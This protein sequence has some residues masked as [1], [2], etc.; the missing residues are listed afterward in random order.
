MDR[1]ERTNRIIAWSLGGLALVVYLMTTAP[2][3][4]FWDNGEFIAVGYT[5]GVG[6]PPGS[7][8]YTLICR[9]FSFLPFPN[10]AR[11]VNFESILAGALGIVFLYL[12][13]AKMA[14]RWEGK[15]SSFSD[16]LPT[17]VAGATACTFAAFSFSYWENSL[18][19]EVYATNILIMLATLWLVL[20]WSEIRDV[21]RDR[22]YLYL[23]TY[24]LG[25]GIGVHMGCLLWAPAFLLFVI[26]FERNFLG[27]V[28]L[29]VPLVLG[30][31]LASKGMVLRGGLGLWILWLAITVFYAAPALWGKHE[32]LRKGTKGRKP[33]R[34]HPAV[35]PAWLMWALG[36]VQLLSAFAAGAAYGSA[37]FGWVLGCA[38]AGAGAIFLFAYLLRVGI[39]DQPEIPSRLVLAAV[40]LGVVAL[41]THAYLLIR[42]RLRPSI[43]ESDPSTWSLVLDVMR[44]KQYEPMRFFPRRTPFHNQFQIL[45]TY[46]R[47][48][49]TVWPLILGAWGAI[50]HARKDKRTFAMMA[51]GYILAT[52]GLLFYLNISDHE[53]RDR[54]YFWVPSYVGIA[55]WMGIGSGAI[56]AWARKLGSLYRNTMVV[57]LLV[58]SFLPFVTHYHVMDRSRNNVAYCY[59]WNMMN[60]LEP[61]AILITNGDNDTFPLWYLQEVEHL[62]PDVDVV[63][64]SLIQINWYVE[65]LKDRHIPMTFTYEQI[66]RMQPYWVRDPETGELKL[67]TLKDIALQDIIQQALPTRPIYFAVTVEDFMGYYDYLALEGMVFKLVPTEGHH[68]INAEKTYENIF[69]NYRYDSIVDKDD[70]WRV[71]DEIYKPPATTRLITNY[72]AGFSRLGF[73]AMQDSPQRV[74]EAIRLYSI[75]LKFSSDYGPALNGLIAI[76]AA[77]LL[78]PQKAL[79]FAE[80]LIAAQPDVNESWIRYAGVNLMIGEKLQGQGKSGDARPYFEKSMTSYERALS[81]EPDR[82]EIYA[83]L[84]SVYQVL[85]EDQKA[86]SL[87][88][89][90]RQH[91]PDD[92]QAA[93][94]EAQRYSARP[95]TPPKPRGPEKPQPGGSQAPAPGGN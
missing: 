45:W 31:V 41:S 44:R 15:V 48:Q 14:K 42:A 7:P 3:V 20:R 69:K 85:G 30:F 92:L 50:A 78:Q 51:T 89:L 16:G 58:F 63:N 25:L 49:F 36:A 1:H 70:N 47:P 22:R 5:L 23:V 2:N 72:A 39:I 9:L 24:L 28:L 13:I 29:G 12:S 10:V 56:V 93:I 4:A 34:T 64:L 71:M 77:K 66:R 46:Y 86:E 81:K 75:S 95:P 88:E 67:I 43:N 26:L 80:R 55:L 19:A 53:V 37:G 82:V 52:V 62:R 33:P 40:A 60:F 35:L 27:V 76:Y 17:Y 21:P 87:L 11:A 90:W 59:G 84:L 74:D 8:L 32:E 94:E 18:E 61:N 91:A 65:Q 68:Q 6:H 83:P 79:P 54:E 73:K 38:I 57:A